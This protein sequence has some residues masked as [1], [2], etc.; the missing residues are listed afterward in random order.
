MQE[1]FFFRFFNTVIFCYY[2][3]YALGH[4]PKALLLGRRGG[5][6]ETQDTN[7]AKREVKKAPPKIFGERRPDHR[8]EN[9]YIIMGII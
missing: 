6:N 2:Y 4:Q 5:T 1:F 8:K 9:Q 7:Q 3:L